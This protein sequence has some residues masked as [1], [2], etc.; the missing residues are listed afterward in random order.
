[1]VASGAVQSPSFRRKPESSCKLRGLVA[2][3]GFRRHDDNS[4]DSLVDLA[5]ARTLK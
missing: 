3:Y 4:A 1:L 5:A 2:G